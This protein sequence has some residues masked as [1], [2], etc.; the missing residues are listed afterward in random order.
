[1][2]RTRAQRAAAERAARAADRRWRRER[3]MGPRSPRLR[4]R[5]RKRHDRGSAAG[6]GVHP[7]ANER[8]RIVR[9]ILT[10]REATTH[11][12][13]GTTIERA[14]QIALELGARP[15]PRRPGEALARPWRLPAAQVLP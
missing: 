13:L 8:R 9:E 12:A 5:E 11:E 15:V 4:E 1:M 6:A 10:Q 14:R 7:R 3:G 2:T